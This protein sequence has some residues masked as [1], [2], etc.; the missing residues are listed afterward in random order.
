MEDKR[1]CEITRA[2]NGWI[3]SLYIPPEPVNPVDCMMSFGPGQF[4]T[5]E[6]LDN[7]IRGKITSLFEAEKLR[8]ETSGVRYMVFTDPAKMFAYL[9]MM[10]VEM[11][12]EET[13]EEDS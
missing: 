13:S 10:M 5:P 6:E 2:D 12:E 4:D 8:Q 9:N 7:A 3:V 1:S 11:D